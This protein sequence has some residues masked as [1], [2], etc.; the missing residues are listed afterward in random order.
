MKKIVLILLFLFSTSAV[1]FGAMN[2]NFG[3][4]QASDATTGLTGTYGGFDVKGYGGKILNPATETESSRNTVNL[5]VSGTL[6]S[7]NVYGGYND[8][9]TATFKVDSNTVNLR[10]GFSSLQGEINGGENAS[11]DATNNT[12]NIYAGSSFTN[13]DIWGGYSIANGNASGN[14]INIEGG[15]F[16][17]SDIMAGGAD[18]GDAINNIVNI[19]GDT[20]F[21]NVHLSGGYAANGTASDN[22]LNLS[23]NIVVLGAYGFSNYNFTVDN[24]NITTPVL[25]ATKDSVDMKDS[26]VGLYLKS[27]SKQLKA[28]DKIFLVSNMTGVNINQA[29]GKARAGVSMIYDWTIDV[30]GQ[31]LYAI[32]NS[33]VGNAG[34]GGGEAGKFNPETKALSEGHLSSMGVLTSGAD[35][36]ADNGINSADTTLQE[37]NMGV[38]SSLNFNSVRLNSGSYIDLNSSSFVLG[39][40]KKINNK[41]LMGA[42]LE[43]GNGSHKT[44]NKTDYS[45]VKGSGD[46]LYF[47][48]GLLGKYSFESNIYLDASVRAG[49]VNTNYKADFSPD[50]KYNIGALYY[51]GHIGAGYKHDVSVLTF[52]EYVKYLATV[53]GGNDVSFDSGEKAKF[54]DVIS[55]RVQAGLR[56]K[57][58]SVFVGYAYEQELAGEAKATIDNTA[59]DAPSIKGGT[60]I[61]EAGYEKTFSHFNIGA[62]VKGYIGAR[63]GYSI[64]AKVGYMF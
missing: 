17:D 59:I 49:Y 8:N 32:I 31:D 9:T 37:N 16:V 50:A 24:N 20:K 25:M 63:D 55:S 52:N 41:Y 54:D 11:G 40:G 33:D 18:G 53:Q 46:N 12:V 64:N 62:G 42:F 4:K 23:T 34:S 61:I 13:T 30:N 28:G 38:F 58:S 1:S 10:G 26:V 35:L 21:Q 5:N 15:N 19:S 56:V 39:V 48:A 14:I 6:N 29:S 44:N 45:T 36:V 7:L 2:A 3:G 51:G 27:T 47:G 43:T 60:N 22:T 57:Y